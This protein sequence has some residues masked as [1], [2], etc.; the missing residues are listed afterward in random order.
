MMVKCK[1]TLTHGDGSESFTKGELYSTPTFSNFYKLDDRT[2][3]INNQG[4]RHGVANWLK[5]FKIHE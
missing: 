1:K 3:L 4:E 5:H 2:V